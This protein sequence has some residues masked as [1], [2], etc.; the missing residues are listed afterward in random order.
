MK[1]RLIS[2]AGRLAGELAG[3]PALDREAL[4]EKWRALYGIEPPDGLRNKF[5]MHAIAYRLQEKALGGLKPATSRFLEKASEE[6]GSAKPILPMNS[7]KPGTRLLREWHGVTHE[8]V[9]VENGVK[10]NG[11]HYSSL[12]EVA[13]AITGARWSGPLFFGLKKREVA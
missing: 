10:F 2:D 4:I 11:K 9:I 5:L 3:L 12:S 7:I 13:R 1:H 8:A 6:N